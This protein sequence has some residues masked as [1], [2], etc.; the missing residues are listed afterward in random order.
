MRKVLIVNQFYLKKNEEK[1]DKY[2][3]S[4]EMLFRSIP[5]YLKP[6]RFLHQL[7]KLPFFYM[8]YVQ[9]FT[10]IFKGYDLIILHDS[11]KMHANF[12]IEK[13]TEHSDPATKLVYYYWNSIYELDQLV[14][15]DRWEVLSFDYKDALENDLRYV[16]GFFVPEKMETANKSIDLFFVGTNKGRF[17][18]LQKLE[19]NLKKLNVKTQFF[20]VSKKHFFNKEY[21][22]AIPYQS[23]VDWLSRSKGIVELTKQGQ[24]GLTLRAYEAIFYN[25]KLVSN[26]SSLQNY[27]FYDAEK[28]YILE[29]HEKDAEKIARFL[30]GNGIAY[31]P[32]TVKNYSLESFLERVYENLTL[33][34]VNI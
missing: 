10:F 13:I 23:V 11:E 6:F 21:S 14:M 2:D 3:L 17:S 19:E 28:I 8:W 32:E 18:Y 26:N 30:Q 34:N 22:A 5:A 29:D 20:L 16:G 24:Y 33:R 7:L 25:K 27:D 1:L 9:D 15:S 4:Y 12:F 31:A